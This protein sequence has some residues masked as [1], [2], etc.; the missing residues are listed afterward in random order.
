MGDTNEV[1]ID[2]DGDG[3]TDGTC[4]NI[5][6]TFADNPGESQNLCEAIGSFEDSIFPTAF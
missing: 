2:I 4:V 1:P 3:N 5:Q 6:I